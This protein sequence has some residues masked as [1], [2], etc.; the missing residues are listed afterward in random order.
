[1]NLLLASPAAERTLSVEF[2]AP[3]QAVAASRCIAQITGP[4][5][6]QLVE[7]SV[8]RGPWRRCI[9]ACGFWWHDCGDLPSGAHRLSVRGQAR[10]GSPMNALPRRF[11]VK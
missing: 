4:D 7:I 3:D 8:D 2:P 9:R 5:D 6:A 11:S 10:D 1:M